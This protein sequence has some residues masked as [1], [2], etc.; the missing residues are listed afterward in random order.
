[1]CGVVAKSKSNTVFDGNKIPV[2]QDYNCGTSAILTYPIRYS[3]SQYRSLIN[4]NPAT[5]TH[6]RKYLCHSSLVAIPDST[7]NNHTTH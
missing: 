2:T 5:T 4:N 7:F 3:V 6:Y 1:M